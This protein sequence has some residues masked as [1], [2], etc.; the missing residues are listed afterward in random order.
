MEEEKTIE[1]LKP[2]IAK[3]SLGI[4]LL[5]LGWLVL[6][7]LSVLIEL[8]LPFRFSMLDLVNA[9]VLILAI[10]L[11]CSLGEKIEKESNIKLANFSNFEVI[12]KNLFY[13]VS[14]I[15]AYFAYRNIVKPYLGEYSWLYIFP[16]I[17]AAFYVIYITFFPYGKNRVEK[18]KEAEYDN[19]IEEIAE[20]FEN[21]EGEKELKKANIEDH[22]IEDHDI[23]DYDEIFCRSCGE[24]LDR[25]TYLCLSC[26]F[27]AYELFLAQK[28]E[29]G[30]DKAGPDLSWEDIVL[31]YMCLPL[32]DV[33][34]D[35]GAPGKKDLEVEL[36]N[37][38]AKLDDIP[39]ISKEELEVYFG[40]FDVEY[41]EKST[42]LYKVEEN[43]EALLKSHAETLIDD[44]TEVALEESLTLEENEENKVDKIRCKN[45]GAE[46]KYGSIFCNN[47]FGS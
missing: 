38:E 6:S 16:F 3:A 37:E 2:H 27:A 31:D 8:E 34:F 44:H 22:D 23:E 12:L 46:M 42:S 25:E 14:V 30:E 19:L 21:E 7:N 10:E 29:V 18:N 32:E 9:I 5:F 36:S 20:R 13:L 43:V 47:C 33:L 24:N 41:E 35:M 26:S 39:E 17:I 28:N 11:L 1:P 40:E 4:I 15:I 45:C